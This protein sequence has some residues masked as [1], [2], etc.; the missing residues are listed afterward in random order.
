MTARGSEMSLMLLA[1]SLAELLDKVSIRPAAGHEV[2]RDLGDAMS[3]WIAS[4]GSR[5]GEGLIRRAQGVTGMINS[6]P[7]GDPLR[8]AAYEQ[9]RTYKNELR[10]LA[11]GS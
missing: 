6:S 5:D 10:A 7:D 1:H 4:G 8:T 11:R 3:E 9:L 2:Q